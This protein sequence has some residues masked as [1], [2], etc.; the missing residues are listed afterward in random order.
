[1]KK[2]L[3]L[4]MAL[5]MLVCLF[6]GC[7]GSGKE[8]P[9]IKTGTYNATACTQDGEDAGVDGEYLEIN[10]DG[11]G[12]ICFG[13]EEYDFDWQLKGSRFSFE[14]E[15]GD[16]FAGTYEDGV[17][18]GSYYGYDYVFEMTDSKGGGKKGSE[19]EEAPAEEE[20][21]EEEEP[22]LEGG[23]YQAIYCADGENE[24]WCNE[25]WLELEEDGS[26]IIVFEGEEFD[27]EWTLDGEDF[28]FEV[29]GDTIFVGSHVDG[30]IEGVLSVRE[31][32][33]YV[34]ELGADPILP[35]DEDSAPASAP[36]GDYDSVSGRIGDYEIAFV[37]A[38]HFEDIDDEPGIRIYYDFTNNSDETVYAMED[39]E[40]LAEQEGFELNTTMDSA[41]DD[42]PEYGNDWLCVRPGVTIRCIEEYS[43]KEG[44]DL[45]TVTIQDWWEEEGAVTATF[46]PNDLPG[47]PAVD[48]EPKPVTDPQ[49]TLPSSG[50]Y[51]EDYEVTIVGCEYTEDWDGNPALRVYFDF[52][53]NGTEA[54][55]FWMATNYRALQDGVELEICW[56]DDE[57]DEDENYDVEIEPG[58]T[59]TCTESY[60][61]RSD[62]PVE[63]EFYSYMYDGE[64]VLAEIFPVEG[65]G[66]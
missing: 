10:A 11:S 59:I 45:V 54:Q 1:M 32:Y 29:D 14:D 55:S 66:E 25:D 39:L 40:I 22:A 2:S 33:D 41:A 63:V 4:L 12:V 17:I 26:G 19:P 23:L 47:R 37:G 64:A 50:A 43:Y 62:S 6:A 51:E 52:T 15:D 57:V 44:G 36:A 42:V 61:L 34:F 24:Y 31:D 20:V 3:A 38:E 9:D 7:G 49:T 28:S 18:E 65:M 53:N 35:E 60:L 30:V 8:M 13:G 21:P 48:W 58:E 46:D 56:P 5:A 16:S 27:L